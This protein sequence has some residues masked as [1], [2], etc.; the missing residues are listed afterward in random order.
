MELTAIHT[1]NDFKNASVP[2]GQILTYAAMD[3]NGKLITRYKDSAGSFGTLTDTGSGSSG[4]ADSAFKL[5]KILEH[6][7]YSDE[8]IAPDEITISGLGVLGDEEWG[9]DASAA[10]GTYV[11]MPGYE[12]CWEQKRVFKHE[13]A[14]YYLC[15]YDSKLQEEPDF[16]NHWYISSRV[17]NYGWD[18][19]VYIN[20]FQLFNGEQTWESQ[21]GSVTLHHEITYQYH[22][23]KPFIL[24]GQEVR[25][26]DI[27]NHF[28]DYS[29]EVDLLGFEK[30]AM[31][32]SIYAA[33]NGRVIGDPVGFDV[34]VPSFSSVFFATLT[35]A[36][37]KALTGQTLDITSAHTP[38]ECNGLKCLHIAGEVLNIKN[39]KDTFVGGKNDFSLLIKVFFK[40]FNAGGIFV[41]GSNDCNGIAIN[42]TQR[43]N[44][45]YYS[46]SD[47]SNCSYQDGDVEAVL[48]E[49]STLCLIRQNGKARFYVNTVLAREEDFNHNVEYFENYTGIGGRLANGYGNT[50]RDMYVCNAIMFDRVIS[51]NEILQL[52]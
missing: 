20:V 7:T 46:F 8:F 43:G 29:T 13:S 16:S 45:F 27:Y 19:L 44:S 12:N 2:A 41:L 6:Q 52:H 47:A 3:D 4:T 42:L 26:Y 51:E 32:N 25:F 36:E 39:A 24:R 40:Q 21:Y 49:W 23:V 1:D 22:P 10:N 18:A 37:N 11:V 31:V 5:V 35:T 9:V 48:N 30:N 50:C 14:E 38:A 28:W 15:Y 34:G 17:G 33:V